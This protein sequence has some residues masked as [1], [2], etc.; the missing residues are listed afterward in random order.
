[1]LFNAASIE[2]NHRLVIHDARHSIEGDIVS[3][4]LLASDVLEQLRVGRWD[5]LEFR[6][7]TR[8]FLTPLQNEELAQSGNDIARKIRAAL[9]VLDVAGSPAA[10]AIQMARLAQDVAG[11]PADRLFG[12]LSRAGIGLRRGQSARNQDLIVG[13]IAIRQDFCV[14]TDDDALAR[15]LR[16][17]S[18]HTM[19]LA[20]CLH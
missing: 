1:L 5:S 8:M 6:C 19:P 14:L 11:C 20:D 4:F 3:N 7:L 15:A 17:C 18:G 12:L 10:V 9:R 13:Q 16:Q 2:G